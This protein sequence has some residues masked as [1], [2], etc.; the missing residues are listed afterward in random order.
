MP[1]RQDCLPESLSS[2][3]FTGDSIKTLDVIV[4]G[5]CAKVGVQRVAIMLGRLGQKLGSRS[6]MLPCS[7]TIMEGNQR[8]FAVLSG[9]GTDYLCDIA[10]ETTLIVDFIAAQYLVCTALSLVASKLC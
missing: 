4:S 7:S 6:G 2:F 3:N 10:C 5:S 9:K 8:S 1:R